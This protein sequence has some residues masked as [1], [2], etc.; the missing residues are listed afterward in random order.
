MY[1]IIL[2]TPL[3]LSLSACA[4]PMATENYVNQKVASIE[5]IA[6]NAAA[7]A[8][9]AIQPPATNG[10]LRLED[11]PA[12]E[13][14]DETDPRAMRLYH[15]GD[16]DIQITPE[17]DFG[18]D[19]DTGAI[20]GYTGSNSNIVLPYEIN[21]IPVETIGASAFANNMIVRTLKAPK[22]LTA[23]NYYA[24]D[25]SSLTSLVAP[26]LTSIGDYAFAYGPLTN[27]NAPSLTHIGDN[28][29]SDCPL[30]NLNAP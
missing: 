11:L 3:L 30:T 21:G 6:T 13:I 17:S 22:T 27:L 25:G 4:A 1:K 8:A 16:P 20:T 12:V 2:I 23:I 9:T 15:Y 24:F 18:F 10:F 28:A 14:P 19:S 7:V 26:S 5:I 29:F